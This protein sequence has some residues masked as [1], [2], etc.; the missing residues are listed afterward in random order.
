MA[1]PEKDQTTLN[2]YIQQMAK[3]PLLSPEEEKELAIRAKK[4]DKEALKK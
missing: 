4:G 1:N 2:L 3:H